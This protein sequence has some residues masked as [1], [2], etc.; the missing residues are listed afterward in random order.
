VR[1]IPRLLLASSLLFVA[2]LSLTSVST[3]QSLQDRPNPNAVIRPSDEAPVAG[4]RLTLRQRIAD[5][6]AALQASGRPSATL[7]RAPARS[8][9]LAWTR[10]GAR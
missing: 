2:A 7:Q 6:I 4:S 10:R 9:R 5:A 8:A 3:A 1:T